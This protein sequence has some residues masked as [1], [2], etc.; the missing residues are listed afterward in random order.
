[1]K[2][3]KPFARTPEQGAETLIWLATSPDVATHSGLYYTRNHQADP[4]PA[5]QD[6]TTATRLWETCTAQ[7]RFW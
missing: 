6:P 3:A 1:M 4:S 5:A 7:T 2:M